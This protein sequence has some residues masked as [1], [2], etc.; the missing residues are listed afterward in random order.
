MTLTS[1][2]ELLSET[3]TLGR[4]LGSFNCFDLDSAAGI[5][6]GA[7]RKRLPVILAVSERHLKLAGP[8]QMTSIMLSLADAAS[9][10]VVVHLDHARTL[11]T[12]AA[13]M[14]DGFTSLMFDGYGLSPNEKL[15]QTRAA[16]TFAHAVGATMETELGHIGRPS[17]EEAGEPV[18]VSEAADFVERTGIDTLA[19]AVGSA[20]GLREGEGSIDLDLL[21]DLHS[22]AKCFLSLHGGSGIPR[23]DLS[24]AVSRGVVKVSVFTRIAEA[25]LA[26]LGKAAAAGA[27]DLVSVTHSVRD[28]FAAEVAHVL[29]YLPAGKY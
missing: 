21:D 22:E 1:S 15:D 6:Q 27:S 3:A 17:A 10:P 13:C 2:R 28:V 26:A 8:K 20:H 7:E 18:V 29:D 5:I 12:V 24:E 9:V 11:D 16:T 23:A 4:L 25:A 14:R 19:A